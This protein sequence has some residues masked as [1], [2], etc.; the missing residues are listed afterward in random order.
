MNQNNK[1]VNA[2]DKDRMDIEIKAL[3]ETVV[4][5][6][7]SMKGRLNAMA[8]WNYL[9]L[10]DESFGWVD[11]W[12]GGMPW[13]VKVMA[14]MA[15]I[16]EGIEPGYG[17]LLFLGNS[18]YMSASYA[19]TK[20]LQDP[21]LAGYSVKFKPLSQEERETYCIEDGDAVLKCVLKGIYDGHEIEWEGIGIIDKDE[22]NKT[23]KHGK[24]MQMFGT[25][26]NLVNT[27]QTRAVHNLIKY[28]YE[29]S[30]P[31]APAKEEVDELKK[32]EE[33][34]LK[35]LKF[36][37]S[38]SDEIDRSR[39]IEKIKTEEEEANKASLF[40]DIADIIRDLNKG[41]MSEKEIKAT[42]NI[43]SGIFDYLQSLS[44]NDLRSFYD[45]ISALLVS[46]STEQSEGQEAK[47]SDTKSKRK[48]RTKA[49]IEAEKLEQENKADVA[50]VF[51]SVKVDS[52]FDEGMDELEPMED[53]DAFDDL[54]PTIRAKPDNAKLA[55]EAIKTLLA[56][57][58][59]V[60]Q[61]SL[62]DKLKV[63]D[64]KFL[65]ENDKT[66]IIDS[67]TKAVAQK[68]L[69]LLDKLIKEREDL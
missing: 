53:L 58:K 69:T 19:R 16:Q 63:L 68:D 13:R 8:V 51:N 59:I 33:E 30:I 4:S 44:I 50:K 25:R 14:V 20:M 24:K 31:M 62:I 32:T 1:I 60:T 37:D 46:L 56:H 9:Q 45:Q 36:I 43:T 41:G 48:R 26:K 21:N 18:L 40:N 49:E 34:A 28:N 66:L 47:N 55:Y 22:K 10:P 65:L 27:L 2:P 12:K 61:P 39:T 23:D 38:G 35:Q 6:D 7:P 11:G 42:Y 64:A 3:I 54:M 29:T 67:V 52:K 5:R 57:P 17:H 15:H